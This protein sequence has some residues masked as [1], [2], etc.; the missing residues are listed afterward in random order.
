[1]R[2]L[3]I[4]AGIVA[5]MCILSGI[6]LTPWDTLYEAGIWVTAA[7]FGLGV[8]TG[9]LYHVRLYRTLAPRGELPPGWYWRPLRFN[10]RLRADE[11]GSVMVWCYVGGFGFAVICLGLLLMG[12]GVSMAI[13]RGV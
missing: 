10:G 11:R 7:G 9:V 12:A 4:V 6:W 3:T 1:M 2:E 5:L 13:V 8:P